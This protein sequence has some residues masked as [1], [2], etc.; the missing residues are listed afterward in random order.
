MTQTENDGEKE[1][2]FRRCYPG[3]CSYCRKHYREVGPLAEGPD[4]VLICYGCTQL[5]VRCIE[6]GLGRRGSVMPWTIKGWWEKWSAQEGE[7][8]KASDSHSGER[9]PCSENA[10]LQVGNGTTQVPDAP[11]PERVQDDVVSG[12]AKPVGERSLTRS[13]VV[14]KNEDEGGKDRLVR[15][16]YPGCCSFCRKHHHE[17]GPLAEGPDVVLICYG[18]AH[19]CARCIEEECQ[20]LGIAMPWTVAGWWEKKAVEMGAGETVQDFDKSGS[21][22]EDSAQES[23]SGTTQS[24]DPSPPEP[25]RVNHDS[26]V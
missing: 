11:A 10:V 7:G 19:A 5:C 23:G 22:S 13:A 17:V 6:D 25:Q 24:P 8:K 14:T 16:C 1:G 15:R 9:G 12:T 21:S 3:Y 18:C 26:A 4:V 20:R 2:S